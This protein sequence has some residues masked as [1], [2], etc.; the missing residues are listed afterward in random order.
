MYRIAQLPVALLSAD[1][2][3]VLQAASSDSPLRFLTG[4]PVCLFE[5]GQEFEGLVADL[6]GPVAVGL[7]FAPALSVTV[8]G[9]F[10]LAWTIDDV[11]DIALRFEVG[12]NIPIAIPGLIPVDSAAEG[13]LLVT[14]TIVARLSMAKGLSLDPGF[15]ASLLPSRIGQTD[16][17]IQADQIIP[18]LGIPTLHGSSP[19]LEVIGAMVTLPIK[20]ET[21]APL[22]L[23][24]KKLRLD[25]DG[26][27]AAIS[28]KPSAPVTWDPIAQKFT[29]PASGTYAG[30]ALGL[31]SL[32]IG[33]V[34]NSIVA[35]DGQALLRLPF[36][37]RDLA[38]DIAIA[39]TGGWH[40]SVKPGSAP[41]NIVGS[42]EGTYWLALTIDTLEF[43]STPADGPCLR[44]NAKLSLTLLGETY[45]NIPLP[46]LVITSSGDVKLQGG[47]LPLKKPLSANLGPFS[48]EIGRIGLGSLPNGD[49]QL[50]LDA[51]VKLS[52]SMPASGAA[53][54]LR[55]TFSKDWQFKGLAF[56]GIKVEVTIPKVMKFTGEVAMTEQFN[57]DCGKTLTSFVG[58]VDVDLYALDAK[59]A[60][61]VLFGEACKDQKSFKYVA[62]K[63]ELD[64]K[65]GKQLFGTGLALYG[66]TGLFAYN[67]TPDKAPQENWYAVD[68]SGWL[69]KA[70]V[71][72]AELAKW[73]PDPGKLAFGAGVT[74][75]T[76]DKGGKAFNGS[77]M[78]LVTLPGPVIFLDGR[79]NL[80]RDRK[81]LAKN[82]A[83]RGYA[84]LDA[85]AGS[86]Q[87]GLDA[88]WRYP[89]GGELIDLSGSAE[90]FFDFH[91]AGNWYINVGL[92]NPESARIKA[93]LVSFFEANAFL[94]LDA[95]HARMG[96]KAGYSNSAVFGPLSFGVSLWYSAI[97][98]ISWSPPQLQAQAGV[99]GQAWASAFGYTLSLAA[100]AQVS[101]T[102]W[103]PF[104]IIADASASGSLPVYGKFSKSIKLEWKAPPGQ[105]APAPNAK[106]PGPRVAAPLVSVS[107]GHAL[108][109]TSWPL[110]LLPDLSDD[111][112]MLPPWTEE[113]WPTANLKAEPPGDAPVLPLDARIDLRFALPVADAAKVALVGLAELPADRIGN[114][115]L[116]DAQLDAKVTNRLVGLNL[117]RWVAGKWQ[118][119]A[120]ETAGSATTGLADPAS[121]LYGVWVPIAGDAVAAN[122]QQHLRLWATDPLEA[123]LSPSGEQSQA[124]GKELVAST[125]LVAKVPQTWTFGFASLPKGPV[126]Q[127]GVWAD[128]QGPAVEWAADLQASIVDVAVAGVV[129]AC[130]QWKVGGFGAAKAKESSEPIVTPWGALALRDPNAAE[131][132]AIAVS[133]EF[134]QKGLTQVELQ[135]T[136]ESTAY[137]AVFSG[138]VLATGQVWAPGQGPLVLAGKDLDH[139]ILVGSKAVTVSKLVLSTEMTSQKTVATKSAVDGAKANL[140]QKSLL[141][142]APGHVLPADS[143]LRL[144]VSVEVAQTT[145]AGLQP[146]GTKTLDQVVYFRT[147]GGPGLADLAVPVID[148]AMDPEQVLRDDSGGQVSVFGGPAAVPA[149]RSPLNSLHPYILRCL[150]AAPVGSEP[151][152]VWR[153]VDVGFDFNTGAVRAFFT[154]QRRDLA[155]RVRDTSGAPMLDADGDALPAVADWLTSQSLATS[156]DVKAILEKWQAATGLA[157]DVNALGTGDRIRWSG[158]VLPPIAGL[159]AELVPLLLREGPDLPGSTLP[160]GWQPC[161]VGSTKPTEWKLIDKSGWMT[162]AAMPSTVT[163][164]D[165]ASGAGLFWHGLGAA[166]VCNWTDFR[167]S[168]DL[169]SAPLTSPGHGMGVVL[170]GNAAGDAGLLCM[171]EPASGTLRAVLVS[172]GQPPVLLGELVSPAVAEAPDLTAVILG[173][174]LWVRCGASPKLRVSWR[175]SVGPAS[176]S[177][178]LFTQG[179]SGG[180][181]RNI[182]VQDLSDASRP[183]YRHMFFTSSSVD[184]GHLAATAPPTMATVEE[185][186]KAKLTADWVV[187]VPNSTDCSIP[188]PQESAV[189]EALFAAAAPKI[190]ELRSPRNGLQ[191]VRTTTSEATPREVLLLRSADNL[192]WRRTT[193]QMLAPKPEPWPRTQ[194]D[195]AR[196]GAGVWSDWGGLQAIDWTVLQPDLGAKAAIEWLGVAD[197]FTA[198]GDGGPSF[199]LAPAGA[200]AGILW[201]ERFITGSL[202]LWR[203][204][205]PPPVGY[206]WSQKDGVSFTAVQAPIQGAVLLAPIPGVADVRI[207]ARLTPGSTSGEAGLV[208]RHTQPNPAAPASQIAIVWTPGVGAD[209]A[210]LELRQQFLSQGGTA[211]SVTALAAPPVAEKT[212]ILE[213]IAVGSTLAIFANRR[214]AGS[215]VDPKPQAGAV[216]LWVAA[217][218]PTVDVFTVASADSAVLRNSFDELKPA[219]AQTAQLWG[220][221]SP[222]AD[223]T[224]QPAVQGTGADLVLT[225]APIPTG[226]QTHQ[227]GAA[228]ILPKTQRSPDQFADW[229]F[230]VEIWLSA[231]A[232]AGIAL[233]FA[234]VANCAVITLDTLGSAPQLVQIEQGSAKVLAPDGLVAAKEAWHSVLVRLCGTSVELWF[235]GVARFRVDL[236][237]AAAG[238][239]ALFGTG[240]S[241]VRFRK[242]AVFD[243]TERLAGWQ[244][245]RVPPIAVGTAASALTIP[246]GWWE[247]NAGVVTPVAPS[248]ALVTASS[249]LQFALAGEPSWASYV[250]SASL[251][252]QPG[253][254]CMVVVGWQ[255]PLNYHALR[256]HD[257]GADW[258][259]C[260]AGVEA[261]AP[262]IANAALWPANEPGVEITCSPGRIRV[263]ASSGV[264]IFDGAP[265]G[266]TSGRCGLAALPS[267]AVWLESFAVRP[268]TTRD[269]AVWTTDSGQ[270]EL[271]GWELYPD[272]AEIDG[273]ATWIREGSTIR[274]TS[275]VWI[276]QDIPPGNPAMRGAMLWTP[277]LPC[278]QYRVEVDLWSTDGDAIGVALGSLESFTIV[279]FSMDKQRNYWR[280]TKQV[281]N[282]F[283]LLW[284]EPAGFAPG[285]V[286]HVVLDLSDSGLRGF[287]DGVP[288]FWLPSVTEPLPWV[289]LYTYAN[290]GAHFSNLLVSRQP[291]RSPTAWL[292]D[293]FAWQ[294]SAWTV[295]HD[296]VWQWQDGKLLGKLAAGDDSAMVHAG[297]ATWTD[298]RAT[299]VIQR[300]AGDVTLVVGRNAKTEL[301]LH[302]AA[303]E[304]RWQLRSSAIDAPNAS[305]KNPL[306]DGTQE[307][308]PLGAL[309]TFAI[310]IWAG[311]AIVWCNGQQVAAVRPLASA[312]GS[313]GLIIDAGSAVAVHA[314]CVEPAAWHRVGELGPIPC[315]Q[316]KTGQLKLGPSA[317]AGRAGPLR[318]RIS[319]A[320]GGIA[321]AAWLRSTQWLGKDSRLLRH[322]DGGCAAIVEPKPGAWPK[323]ALGLSLVWRGSN[324]ALGAHAIEIGKQCADL[325]AEV[326]LMSATGNS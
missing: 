177:V 253:S 235:D 212:L 213:V 59:V 108:V 28:L 223:W 269:L 289:G 67:Y 140:A 116:A 19:G 279:R 158:P 5:N 274:Q 250:V 24:A 31:Q 286:L 14:G 96:G 122:S 39:Q 184:L 6:L 297:K 275:N 80:M 219:D 188:S 166:P 208:L 243:L 228:L 270:P 273:P 143:Q 62:L 155:I 69:Q 176:G 3:A 38:V 195:K 109:A 245:R 110:T 307:L 68:G 92:E 316:G 239:L 76:M 58:A 101:V 225:G 161:G 260:A 221:E 87:F 40:I 57:S 248:A 16:L 36:F 263:V 315:Q 93:K 29:G 182:A 167:L 304:G 147:Q 168:V 20:D 290:P 11:G 123:L 189:A 308:A 60:G 51:A 247:V 170:R 295:G 267:A 131:D 181:F 174:D 241:E 142:Q 298:Y 291:T 215:Y 141:L 55:L 185:A 318:V 251:R 97:A 218:T 152:R 94:R 53:K 186:A 13:S 43:V 151:A 136:G 7:P 172:P 135:L 148:G 259:L 301:R 276:D 125:V 246:V 234:D 146:G 314:V 2:A 277:Q 272:K 50:S 249:V 214:F 313:I 129:T 127:S 18:D 153:S 287:V 72:V 175:S 229:L 321:H 15:C 1:L 230:S 105:K 244:P 306:A 145:R 113:N 278:G 242:P 149:L 61:Q 162:P 159:A 124:A 240:A 205:Q 82:A 30:I 266:P 10:I 47:W 320:R 202:D 325:Q 128:P 25:G 204:S 112:G 288:T 118:T 256:I 254:T 178:V 130:L 137:A 48:V 23:L 231:K 283:T 206:A 42:K 187:A 294:T 22:L 193:L 268:T 27:T 89:D 255:D 86:A 233:G 41:I 271:S 91:D 66:M 64:L 26:V 222:A 191:I 284:E 160:T 296:D 98:D 9:N 65:K 49:R 252:R 207:I 258:L 169:N 310:D 4:R 90:A 220:A 281:L 85:L 226:E 299:F 164:T 309:T 34:K 75:G 132:A 183:L 12:A 154:A 17:I 192:D 300:E 44:L 103:R 303:S 262:V 179:G 78:L 227:P 54:G 237:M 292:L 21:G 324:P 280:V 305:V 104:H 311:A 209:P 37:D 265:D 56:D 210:K 121:A 236:P 203:Q 232:V 217:G 138:G 144:V 173:D 282:T 150:P 200:A 199:D 216:G 312:A 317:P 163:G 157:I 107:A 74:V 198:Q 133:F 71:G 180:G 302:L 196:L 99:A 100:S 79:A 238:S 32:S 257:G 261:L 35:A 77:F 106:L 117:S 190:S 102:A 83:F 197:P 165:W 114:P 171:V 326:V 95:K 264:V 73:K 156:A 84:V 323:D 88:K 194:P 201:C 63:L 126:T 211:Q 293:T 285:Q 33:L 46:G 70:P 119:V 111:K 134:K 224:L 322:R 45:E 52:D 81:E 8:S 319:D 139:L 115:A 120:A